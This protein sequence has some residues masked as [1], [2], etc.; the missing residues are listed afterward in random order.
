MNEP[1]IKVFAASG[2]IGVVAGVLLYVFVTD[3]R[4]DQAANR[5]E[6]AA[7]R[8]E[9]AE[10]RAEAAAETK[11]L[12]NIL[13]QLLMSAERTAYLQRVTCQNQADTPAELRACA[14]DFE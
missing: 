5:S 7:L 2:A 12:I 14:K 4:A 9:Y 8:A 3:V 1:L 6:H 11:Q 10:Q 13:G